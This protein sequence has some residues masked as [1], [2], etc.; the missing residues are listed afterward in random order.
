MEITLVEETTDALKEYGRVPIAFRV[1]SRLRLDP[2]G[3]G[4]GG[5]LLAEEEVQPPYLKDYDSERGEV[6]A[7]WREQ[8]DIAHWGVL[9]AFGGG[10]RVGCTVIAYD[11]EQVR[12]LE[13]RKDLAALWDI[14]VDPGFRR[15]GIGSKLFERAVEWARSRGCR[16]FKVETQ[17]IN[18][19]AC[20]FYAKQG[21]MLGAIHR[22]AYPDRPEEAQLVWWKRIA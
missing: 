14:R 3:N 21:C 15:Q 8:W 12:G 7:R 4:L 22:Y 17:N 20:R 1:E 16:W 5:L 11:T 6:P 19:P 2:V 10:R 13:G 9:S 18:V